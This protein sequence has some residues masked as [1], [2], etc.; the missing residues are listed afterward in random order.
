[1]KLNMLEVPKEDESPY[2]SIYDPGNESERWL[3]IEDD[4]GNTVVIKN[5]QIGEL[6]KFI[7]PPRS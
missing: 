5:E 1:M 4:E 3:Y 2:V 7:K 6:F